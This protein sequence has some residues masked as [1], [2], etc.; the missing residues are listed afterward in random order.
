MKHLFIK[1]LTIPKKDQ[2]HEFYNVALEW[3]IKDSSN[4]LIGQGGGDGEG[5]SARRRHGR[6]QV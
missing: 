1:L 2:N 5:P 4:D 6:A 3:S